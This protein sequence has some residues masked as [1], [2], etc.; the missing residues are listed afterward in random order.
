MNNTM[1]CF[2]FLHFYKPIRLYYYN[3][4]SYGDHAT[5]TEVIY[6]CQCSK[7]VKE[8]HWYGVVFLKEDFNL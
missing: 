4:I 3:D 1:K 2:L 7:H 5:S 8:K 6:K